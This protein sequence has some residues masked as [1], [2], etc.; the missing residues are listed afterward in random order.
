MI[1]CNNPLKIWFFC[2]ATSNYYDLDFCSELIIII[3]IFDPFRL[4]KKSVF[5]EG[6]SHDALKVQHIQ[7]CSFESSILSF[8]NSNWKWRCQLKNAKVFY[9][10]IG[11]KKRIVSLFMFTFHP[12]IQVFKKSL[13]LK[14]KW[15]AS[16]DFRP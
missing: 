12:C 5:T 15:G 8:R 6:L 4:F 7:K 14:Y 1:S 2:L 9:H 13:L 10:L 11:I 3:I 16:C